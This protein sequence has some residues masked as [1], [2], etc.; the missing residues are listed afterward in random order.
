MAS[1]SVSQ[2]DFDAEYELSS[3]RSRIR[4]AR[5]RGAL[6]ATNRQVDTS[7]DY[8]QDGIPD[9]GMAS[10]STTNK[11]GT[12]GSNLGIVGGVDHDTSPKPTSRVKD[13]RT[14]P[15]HIN[16]GK[17]QRDRRKLR[18]KR[19][20]TGVVHLPSTEVSLSSVT[21]EFLGLSL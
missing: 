17:Q 4:V 12:D 10:S 6:G 13:K 9:G 3:R 18:E 20:S 8:E 15:N 2:E 5:T 11:V 7:G 14:R 1:S 16:K 21:F 19:R